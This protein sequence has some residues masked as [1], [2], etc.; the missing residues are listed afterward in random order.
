MAN[1]EFCKPPSVTRRFFFVI[2]PRFELVLL[3][4]PRHKMVILIVRARPTLVRH[5][6]KNRLDKQRH[7]RYM[8]VRLALAVERY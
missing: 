2:R 8:S 6:V 1:L 7:R 5:F 4:C 3:L